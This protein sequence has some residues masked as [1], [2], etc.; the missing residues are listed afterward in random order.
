MLPLVLLAALDEALFCMVSIA[1]IV[2]CLFRGGTKT[3][4]E[5]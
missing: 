5:I 1:I 4:S 2:G 3:K